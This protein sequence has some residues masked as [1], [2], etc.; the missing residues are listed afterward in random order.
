MPRPSAE[1]VVQ[2]PK[3]GDLLTNR[4][5]RRVECLR[6]Y[7]KGPEVIE[8]QRLFTEGT[9]LILAVSLVVSKSRTMIVDLD[10]TGYYPIVAGLEEPA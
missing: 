10:L 4:R 5:P 1:V 7:F 9:M 8:Y 6:I 2:C 3:T